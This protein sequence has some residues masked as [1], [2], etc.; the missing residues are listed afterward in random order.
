MFKMKSNTNEPLS[1]KS[2]SAFS[3]NHISQALQFNNAASAVDLMN[4]SLYRKLGIYGHRIHPFR[5]SDLKTTPE[6]TDIS[7]DL[8]RSY[9]NDI[10]S[11]NFKRIDGNL[12]VHKYSLPSKLNLKS[13]QPDPENLIPRYSYL[14]APKQECKTGDAGEK[15]LR[16]P[17]N[18]SMG[19]EHVSHMRPS[20][21]ND[22]GE[23]LRKIYA[24]SLDR[25]YNGSKSVTPTRMTAQTKIVYNLS[26]IHMQNKLQLL[27]RLG[28][29][30]SR[31][32]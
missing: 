27:S 9:F 30:N 1:I 24:A 2:E 32:D 7:F 15:P 29:R 18:K 5:N 3:F 10:F 13:V 12:F 26:K 21:L 20:S 31:L 22:L 8:N 28:S 14:E 16:K 25:S 17:A 11:R 23:R 19:D 4:P 6:S